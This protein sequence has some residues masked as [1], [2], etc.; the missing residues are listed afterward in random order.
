MGL[1][2]E[3]QYDAFTGE[4]EYDEEEVA[5]E[6]GPLHPEDW[7]DF[8]STHLLNMWMSLRQY[9]EENYINNTIL[10]FATYNDFCHFVMNF[11]R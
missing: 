9:R 8:N 6:Y 4:E 7:M 3:Y 5:E 2:N 1:L 10:N 11:S